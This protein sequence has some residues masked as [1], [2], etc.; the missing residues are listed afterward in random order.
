MEKA[1][2]AGAH[3]EAEAGSQEAQI[4][5]ALRGGVLEVKIHRPNG[6]DSGP[7]TAKCASCRFRWGSRAHDLP[8]AYLCAVQLAS[9]ES[10]MQCG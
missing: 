6:L 9:I 8:V 2:N 1:K 4:L 3:H 10:C 7:P 5:S